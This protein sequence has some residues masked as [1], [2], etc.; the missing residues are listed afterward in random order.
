M[1][2]VVNSLKRRVFFDLDD[3]L[4]ISAVVK[5]YGTMKKSTRFTKMMKET[6]SSQSSGM[7]DHFEIQINTVIMMQNR[8]LVQLSSGICSLFLPL[9]PGEG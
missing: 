1:R 2:A 5:L 4:L 9:T 8:I 7:Y 6:A 3:F